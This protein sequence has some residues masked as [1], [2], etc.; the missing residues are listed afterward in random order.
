[1]NRAFDLVAR[2]QARVHKTCIN[3][4]INDKPFPGDPTPA[5]LHDCLQ[6]DPDGEV[7]EAQQYTMQAEAQYCSTLPDF[8]YSDAATVNAAAVIDEQ[9]N[10]YGMFGPNINN[11]DRAALDRPA[12]RAVRAEGGP[13]YRAH[14][15][16]EAHRV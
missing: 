9:Q 6:S 13:R 1:M 16:E 14:H 2:A 8:G 4:A 11:G 12:T 3:A 7:S 15:E 10:I 5:T